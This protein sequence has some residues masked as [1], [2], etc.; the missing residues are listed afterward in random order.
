MKILIIFVDMLRPDM[1]QVLNSAVAKGPLDEELEKIGGTLYRNCFT[2]AP[3][4]ARSLAC[5][6]S[7]K[8][9]YKNGCDKR[10]KNPKFYWNKGLIC[11][12]LIIRMKKGTGYFLRDLTPSGRTTR[13]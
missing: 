13:I 4:T 3:D 11:P 7:G 10:I 9:P 5:V 1:L 6:W 12:F 8:Y 2:Q